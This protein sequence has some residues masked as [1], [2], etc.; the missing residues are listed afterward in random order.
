MISIGV[1]A[2]SSTLGVPNAPVLTTTSISP[3]NPEVA[4]VWDAIWTV[5]S[6]NG[7]AITGYRIETNTDNQGW[8]LLTTVSSSTTSY[9]VYA[10]IGQAYDLRVFAVNSVGTGLPS[11]VDGVFYYE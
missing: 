8:N 5:P 1:I 11:N 3:G 4:A 7:N 9:R 6:D 2:G 10:D